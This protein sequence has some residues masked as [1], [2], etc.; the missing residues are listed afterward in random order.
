MYFADVSTQEDTQEVTVEYMINNNYNN[1][2]NNDYRYKYQ[3][4]AT[5]IYQPINLSVA[6]AIELLS[7]QQKR[8]QN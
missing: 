4:S 5:T 3:K 6:I 2:N 7:A 8:I 1:N